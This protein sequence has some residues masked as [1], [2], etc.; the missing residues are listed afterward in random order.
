[1]L[2]YG[3]ALD[4]Y[5]KVWYYMSLRNEIEYVTIKT[6]LQVVAVETQLLLPVPRQ[7]WG[8]VEG[9][10]RLRLVFSFDT[11]SWYG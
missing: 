11:S 8:C 6:C 9:K 2:L 10:F 4:K 7:A 5:L 1:M 3:L